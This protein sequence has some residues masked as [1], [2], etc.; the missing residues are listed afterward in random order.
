MNTFD[1]LTNTLI[2]TEPER[3]F[4]LDTAGKLI[5]LRQRQGLSQVRLSQLSGVPMKTIADI[6]R[7]IDAATPAILVE[8]ATAMGH[9]PVVD[10]VEL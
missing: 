2:K 6:E 10:F 3:A 1:D 8:L 5:A 7:G 9:L 4:M